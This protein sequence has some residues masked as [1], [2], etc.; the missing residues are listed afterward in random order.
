VTDDPRVKAAEVNSILLQERLPAI[1]SRADK[2]R[3]QW[4]ATS[5]LKSAHRAYIHLRHGWSEDTAHSAWACRNLLELRIITK[6]VLQSSAERHRF[7]DDMYIDATGYSVCLL[8]AVRA[9]R[10]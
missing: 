8:P 5:L 4:L 7:V 9:R 6:Y 1:E 3:D 2:S 10:G